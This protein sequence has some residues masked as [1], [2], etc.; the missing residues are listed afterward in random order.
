MEMFRSV[1]MFLMMLLLLLLLF[2]P[3]VY[4]INSVNNGC[5]IT[6]TRIQ[7]KA[8]CV[9]MGIHFIPNDFLGHRGLQDKYN[10][11]LLTVNIVYIDADICCQYQP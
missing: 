5:I 4:S 3:F 1:R 6:Y 2:S 10:I 9:A 7:V 11:G 8:N